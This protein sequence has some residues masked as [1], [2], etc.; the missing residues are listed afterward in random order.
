MLG[1]STV[2]GVG[3]KHQA[4][5]TRSSW[6]RCCYYELNVIK[7]LCVKIAT[8]L[9]LLVELR[10]ESRHDHKP[11]MSLAFLEVNNS[12]QQLQHLTHVL[13]R[14]LISYDEVK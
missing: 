2:E 1:Q 13:S 14:C 9:F 4:P 8:L 3:P 12:G 7:R 5:Q 6:I 11:A 10:V